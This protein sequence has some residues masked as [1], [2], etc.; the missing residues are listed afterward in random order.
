[1]RAEMRHD[2]EGL[3]GES[4]LDPAAWQPLFEVFRAN[5]SALRAYRPEAAYSGRADLFLAEGRETSGEEWKPFLP[6]VE[7]H[8]LTGDHYAILKEPHVRMLA[9]RLAEAR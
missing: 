6:G 7:V 1:M 9:A 5:E 3:Y 2:L 8:R 4:D